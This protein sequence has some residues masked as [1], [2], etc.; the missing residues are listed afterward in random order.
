MHLTSAKGAPNNTVVTCWGH[1]C[2]RNRHA[3]D[4]PQRPLVKKYSIAPKIAT[5][6]AKKTE[7]LSKTPLADIKTIEYQNARVDQFEKN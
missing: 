3:Q 5:K 7:W 6:N 4:V 1:H 2:T